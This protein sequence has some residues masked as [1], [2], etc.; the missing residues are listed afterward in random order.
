[1]LTTVVFNKGEVVKLV[2]GAITTNTLI[3]KA[4]N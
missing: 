4:K 2:S 3:N 1:M